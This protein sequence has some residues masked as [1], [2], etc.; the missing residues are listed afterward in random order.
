VI[1][2]DPGAANGGAAIASIVGE[3][4]DLRT[5]QRISIRLVESNY[6]LTTVDNGANNH[7][8][9]LRIAAGVVVQLGKR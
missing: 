2:L 6:V 3:G 8:D 9:N 1:A 7:Q 4:L 5:S